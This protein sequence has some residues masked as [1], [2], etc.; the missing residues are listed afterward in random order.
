MIRHII[1]DFFGTLA[2]YAPRGG[3]A[4]NRRT[5]AVLQT[6]G[7][8]LTDAEFRR[9]FQAVFADLDADASTSL[10]EFSMDDAAVAFFERVERAATA[11]ERRHF[12]RAYIADW[13]QGVELLPNLGAWL[14]H[15]PQGKSV[16]SNTH[17]LAL[18]PE[19]LAS[20][21]L[22][23]HFDHVT[24]SVTHGRRKPHP[25]IYDAHLAALNL[26][27]EETVFVGDDVRCDYHGPRQ[28]GLRAY[29]IAPQPVDGVDD[30]HRI[31][32]LFE[33]PERLD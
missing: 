29:L 17:D 21:G 31:R 25:E 9:R 15:L 8:E 33:L 7:V 23:S 4:P 6:L 20:G 2:R 12:T 18:V 22:E 19:H 11:A 10:R 1:F 26:D 30:A 28:R 3:A 24:L 27:P 5:L 32:H 13:N 14:G 16:L